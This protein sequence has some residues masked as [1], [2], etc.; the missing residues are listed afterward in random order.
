[1]DQAD[2]VGVSWKLYVDTTTGYG[3]SICP[4]FAGCLYTTQASN[5]VP[6][7]QFITDAKHGGLPA[8]SIVTPN[9]KNSQHNK[10]SMLAGDNW[11]GR[12]LTAAMNGPD[13]STT[14]IF[15]AWDDCG[16]FYDHVPPPA[17]TSLGI[18]VPLIAISPYAK[19]GY[20]DG[21]SNGNVTDFDSILQYAE[22]ELGIP[23]LGQ[24]D[25][26][27]GSLEGLFDYTQAPLGPVPLVTTRIPAW[28]WGYMAK[29]PADPD[30][31]T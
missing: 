16:C 18:R 19:A 30:D 7:T 12:L 29:H 6:A 24:G 3:W 26:T 27:A 11:I 17:G 2:S 10:Q 1:M 25:V 8:F 4:T 5:V 21:S 22:V 14:A 23:S 31:P 15:L 9:G 13:W 20:T 28:E